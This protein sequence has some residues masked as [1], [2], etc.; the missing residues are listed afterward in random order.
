M[1]VWVVRS[2]ADPRA[3]CA[4]LPVLYRNSVTL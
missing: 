1:A 3:H 4:N 2:G